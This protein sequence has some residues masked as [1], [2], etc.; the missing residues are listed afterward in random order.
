MRA[1][2][3]SLIAVVIGALALTG[4]MQ[5]SVSVTTGY[6]PVDEPYRLDA[7][8]KL[9]IV[10]Y[11]QEGLTNTYAVGASGA[12]T[13]PLIGSVSARGLTPAE[14]AAAVTARLKRGYL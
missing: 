12:I 5:T 11:G 6:A 9:R 1:S 8:D 7:G 2:R 10:V 3:L 4:C 13:M 14:L